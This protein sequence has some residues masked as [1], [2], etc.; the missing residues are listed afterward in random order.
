MVRRKVLPR[1]AYLRRATD[2]LTGDAMR[3][4][5]LP[6]LEVEGQEEV[7]SGVWCRERSEV[8]EGGGQIVKSRA[9]WWSRG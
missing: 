8:E 6:A 7:M 2:W 5:T 4:G 3:A 9:R 1:A